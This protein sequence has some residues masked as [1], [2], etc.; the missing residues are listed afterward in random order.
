MAYYEDQD[1]AHLLKYNGLYTVF[2]EIDRK[3][4]ISPNFKAVCLDQCLQTADLNRWQV[5]ITS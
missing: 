3:N 1:L 2:P 5:K 4:I